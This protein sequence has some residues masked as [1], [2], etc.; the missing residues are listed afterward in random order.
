MTSINCVRT[1]VRALTGCG[2]A[3]AAS[4]VLTGCHD[5]HGEARPVPRPVKITEARAPDAPASAR[6]AV[7]IVPAEQ[8]PLAFKA[9]GYVDDVLQRRGADGVRRA[10]QA[11]DW[12]TSGDVLARVREADYR[13]R[14][15]QATG[16]LQELQ[17][18]QAKASLD[19]ERARFLFAEQALTKPDLDG[20]QATYDA[21]VARMASAKAQIETARLSLRD[22]ALVAPRS[23]VI[24][25]RKIEVGSLVAGGSVGFVLA[26]VSA[27]KA[28]FGVPDSLVPRLT[29]GE[30]LEVTTEAFRG[31]SFTGRVT[32]ISPSADA[33]SRVFNIE[34]TIA[35]GDG[36]LRP[37]MIGA[38][39]VEQRDGLNAVPH[40]D[41]VAVPLAAIVRSSG[42]AD[43]YSV[44][45]VTGT[46]QDA[47]VSSRPVT[48]G[49]IDGNLVAIT[50][51]LEPGERVV[52][53]GATL[54]KDGE[55]VW[56]IP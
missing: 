31:T 17:A 3:F 36:R 51:G 46:N 14:V 55:T 56:V 5:V 47:N 19:L 40:Q 9:S 37:G 26:D 41:A 42:H 29:L 8:I 32:A 44:F 23:G 30:P 1:S 21:N 7:S 25:D 53:L 13:E 45:V 49:G 52:V 24:L 43:G 22:T 18:A 28:V 16:S 15:N 38:V 39:Q 54:L 20:A 27:V 34:I 6:Y 11:G 35:N 4:L 48:L 10:L 2:V 50:S 12:V 33:Q